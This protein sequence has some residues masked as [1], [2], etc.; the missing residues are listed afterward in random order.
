MSLQTIVSSG[1]AARLRPRRGPAGDVLPSSAQVAVGISVGS[2]R[3]LETGLA[4]T[5][6]ATA[7]L[8]GLG[9]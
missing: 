8:V 2:M 5:A 9:R 6:I 1:L 3:I 4:L 7:V